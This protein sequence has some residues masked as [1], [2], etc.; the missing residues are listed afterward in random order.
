MPL[1]KAI[2]CFS[3]NVELI[4]AQYGGQPPTSELEAALE[5]NLNHGLRNLAIAIRDLYQ[6]LEKRPAPPEL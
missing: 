3:S 1:D 6:A 4:E 2:R 5:W